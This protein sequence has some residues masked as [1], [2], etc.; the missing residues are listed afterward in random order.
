MFE[1]Y[2]AVSSIIRTFGNTVS[3]F[4]KIMGKDGWFLK[5][6]DW[7]AH[8][9]FLQWVPL[10]QAEGRNIK[11]CKKHKPVNKW[12]FESVQLL[13]RTHYKC[14]PVLI[15]GHAISKF[16]WEALVRKIFLDH[17]VYLQLTEPKENKTT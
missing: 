13:L 9:H 16:I 10:L 8:L 6:W 7:M 3:W 17:Q 1:V 11:L 4:I 15:T 14:W 12:E 2:S 5:T